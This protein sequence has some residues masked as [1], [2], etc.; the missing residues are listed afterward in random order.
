MEVVMF[1]KLM[2]LTLLTMTVSHAYSSSHLINDVEC[3]NHETSFKIINEYNPRNDAN[4][5]IA[6]VVG[7]FS[8][9]GVWLWLMAK[10][11]GNLNSQFKFKSMGGGV[12]TLS[13]Q[14][15]IGSGGCGRVLCDSKKIKKITAHYLNLNDEEFFYDCHKILY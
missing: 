8:F 10:D 6:D 9:G 11:D 14:I 2:V 13:E 3:S 7:E 4:A 12:L 5:K 1:K 15:V